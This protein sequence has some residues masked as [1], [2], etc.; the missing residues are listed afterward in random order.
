MKPLRWNVG[1]LL[2]ALVLAGTCFGEEAEPSWLDRIDKIHEPGYMDWIS[3]AW[4][5]MLLKQG[6]ISAEDAPEAARVVLQLWEFDFAEDERAWGQFY[7]NQ[8]FFDKRLDKELAG[9]MMIAR[10]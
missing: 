3:T 8:Y 1:P 7:K 5:T 2:L 10:T 6:I 4:A 9:M